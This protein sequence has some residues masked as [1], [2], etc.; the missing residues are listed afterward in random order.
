MGF[1]PIQICMFS[2]VKPWWRYMASGLPVRKLCAHPTN[3][4]EKWNRKNHKRCAVALSFCGAL[5]VFM[6]RFY[7][8]APTH[9][10]TTYP[11]LLCG[12]WI[13]GVVHFEVEFRCAGMCSRPPEPMTNI[14]IWTLSSASFQNW[15]ISI[16]PKYR[17]VMLCLMGFPDVFA[18]LAMYTLWI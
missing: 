14:F 13:H 17:L 6:E 4:I 8:V 12:R 10:G 2:E 5:G 3:W 15:L 16:Y 9:G 11:D 18:T 7:A 1:R